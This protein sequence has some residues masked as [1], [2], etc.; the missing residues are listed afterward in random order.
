[1]K[2]K[3]SI[4]MMGL[5]PM[6]EEKTNPNLDKIDGEDLLEINS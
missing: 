5:D 4:P 6:V 3:F 2:G 1:V